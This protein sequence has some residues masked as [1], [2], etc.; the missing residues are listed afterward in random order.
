MKTLI[1]LTGLL[2]VSFL[3]FSQDIDYT[4]EADVKYKNKEY[5]EAIELFDKAIG[6]S[7]T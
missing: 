2:L 7:E 4:A 6:E 1:T 5:K 3:S